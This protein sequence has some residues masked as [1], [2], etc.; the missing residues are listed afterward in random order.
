[1]SMRFEN[2]ALHGL[3]Y[4]EAPH[5]ITS[6]AISDQLAPMFQRFNIRNTL[7]EEITGI[8]ARRF[9]DD[10]VQPS[11]VAAQAGEKAI[12][13][14]GIDRADIGLLMSTSVCKDYI[15]PSVASLVHN[16][17]KL[18]TGCINF[19]IGNACLAFLNAMTIAGNMIERGQI[20]HALIVDGEGSRYITDKTVARLLSAEA[21]PKVFRDNFATLTLGSGA[22]AVILSRADLAPKG[23]RFLGGV[24]LAATEYSNLCRGQPEEMITDASKLL[25]AGLGLAQQTWVKAQ[26]VMGWKETEIDEFVLHQVSRTHTDQLSETLGINMDKVHRIYP[27]YGN[28]GPAALPIV[29]AKSVEAG[30]VKAGSRIALMGIG[31]GLNCAMME[32]VW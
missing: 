2:V 27:E 18:D 23:H 26:E 5:R 12:Q 6:A 16:T 32:V 7:L 29:L 14:S 13:A 21:T 15:E 8:V 3:S 28:I 10:G 25:I 24:S 19:D 17:L 30:R 20:K 11:Q 22:A 9:W 4:V 1:M 31:S